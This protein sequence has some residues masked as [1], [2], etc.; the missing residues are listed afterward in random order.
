[1]KKTGHLY[2]E[3]MDA[4]MASALAYVLEGESDAG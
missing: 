4:V 2:S 1:M 3:D